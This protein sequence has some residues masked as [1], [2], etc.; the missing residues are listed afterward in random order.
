[1]V[2][3][4]DF[5][6]LKT[7]GQE[8]A[9]DRSLRTTSPEGPMAL[10]IREH[11]V[12]ELITMDDVLAAVETGFRAMGE[13]QAINR[14]RS[15]AITPLGALHVMHAS[16]PALGVSG[17]KTYASGPRGVT[18]SLL[19]RLEDAYPLALIESSRLGQMRTGA[20]SG[21]ATKYLA[22]P[23]AGALGVIGSGY[24][25]RSQVAAIG[26]VRPVALV[27]VFSRSVESREAFA[28]EMVAELGTE[29]V[30]A[31]SAEEAVDGVD[32]VVT[33]TSSRTP[34]LAGAWLKAGTH[35]NAIGCNVATK[36]EIDVDAVKRADTIVVD[37]LD[38]ARLEC[39]DI[40]AAAEDDPTLWN[41][42]A[43]LGPIVAGH[44]PG[45]RRADEITLFE[46]QGIA[47]ED[48]VTMELLYRRARAAGTGD[49]IRLTAQPSA[50]AR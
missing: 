46:S 14:P 30:A 11:D 45:R 40:I 16:V 42:V 22:R 2:G 49:E 20:A 24:Q 17:V 21:I 7:Q 13:G 18:L 29:V 38:Q 39:G 25:A 12:A 19:Y 37:A 1:M 32:I 43:E 6:A 48:V 47:V 36:Q 5:I 8:S 15:R 28:E 10:L 31:D 41:R 50:V 34:V 35:V 44:L 3:G 23:E 26:R 33:A 4:S 9:H 27:K